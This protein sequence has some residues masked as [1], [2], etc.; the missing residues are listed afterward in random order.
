[1]TTGRRIIRGFSRLGVGA[2][3]L[4]ALCGAA[5][6]YMLASDQ[7]ERGISV[8]GPDNVTVY[9]KNGTDASVINE[10]MSRRFGVPGDLSP[11][12]SSAGSRLSPAVKTASIGIGITAALAFVTWALFRGVGWMLA[13]FAR[14]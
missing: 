10:A 8:T 2:A 1:M 7:F 13:G 5:F 9:F 4:V 6:T 11:A 12:A 3:L 14:D